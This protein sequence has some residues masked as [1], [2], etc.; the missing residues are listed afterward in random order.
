MVIE[1]FFVDI[2]VPFGFV[3]E[4]EVP[5]IAAASEVPLRPRFR[6]GSRGGGFLFDL[7]ACFDCGLVFVCDLDDVSNLNYK[8]TSNHTWLHSWGRFW[9]HCSGES[10]NLPTTQVRWICSSEKKVKSKYLL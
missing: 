4:Q 7:F 1:I 2:I 5:K 3:K 9:M 10:F 8:N 6:L